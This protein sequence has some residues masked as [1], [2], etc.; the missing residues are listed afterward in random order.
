MISTKLWT[1]CVIYPTTINPG[2]MNPHFHKCFDQLESWFY[3][4]GPSKLAAPISSKQFFGLQL[5]FQCSSLVYLLKFNRFEQK[6]VHFLYSK[7]NLRPKNCLLEIGA[8]NLEGPFIYDQTSNTF[9]Q[10]H[11]KRLSKH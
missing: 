10:L 3:M 4:N 7:L 1:V 8:A 11:L 2:T 6:K 9:A 5:C